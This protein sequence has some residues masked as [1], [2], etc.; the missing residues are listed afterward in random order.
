M[1]YVRARTVWTAREVRLAFPALPCLRQRQASHHVAGA[2]FATRVC[3]D[4]NAGHYL[5]LN[6]GSIGGPTR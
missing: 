2:H 1:G 5:T 6:S 3:S 4:K